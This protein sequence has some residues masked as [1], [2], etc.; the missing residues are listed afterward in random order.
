VAQP[1]AM[2]LTVGYKRLRSV[3]MQTLLNPV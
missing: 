3:Q 2:G 1:L